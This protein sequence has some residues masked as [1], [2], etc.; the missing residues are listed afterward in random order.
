M[1]KIAMAIVAHPDDV[2]FNMAGTLILLRERGYEIHYMTVANGSCGSMELPAEEIVAIREKESQNAAK[3]L[4]AIWHPALC[5]DFEIFDT[6]DLRKR[7]AAVIRRVGPEILLIPH[8]NDYMMDHSN[9]AVLAAESAFVR[10]MPNFV[11]EP[12]V[13]P[14]DTDMAVYHC[15]PHG[16]RDIF[17]VFQIPDFMVDVRS[18]WNAKKEALLAHKSQDEFLRKQQGFDAYVEIMSEINSECADLTG[19]GGRL[20]EGW[21]RHNHLGFGSEYFDPLV[22]AVRN[23]CL[24]P[25]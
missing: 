20:V 19:H 5:N 11:T 15:Q 3:I 13:D 6:L 16:N 4:G 22:N 21:C 18:V 10:K 2:E 9:T 12:V 24:L 14:I 8:P 7:L 25:K 1:K 23:M 17:R